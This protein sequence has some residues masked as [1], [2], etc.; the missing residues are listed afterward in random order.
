MERNGLWNRIF[1]RNYTDTLLW[2][3]ATEMYRQADLSSI[4]PLE[5]QLRTPS[6]RP[7]LLGE[8]RMATDRQELV[9]SV[10][11]RRSEL[12]RGQDYFVDGSEGKLL[13]YAPEENLA[14]GAAKHASNG[15]FDV[16]N[17]PPWDTWVV[18]SHGIL[19]SWVPPQ[20]IGL[21]QS[22]IEVNPECCVRWL[23]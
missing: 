4:A 5:A 7:T 10:V 13:L 22:G 12:V 11:V 17:V 21:A 16:D 23:D 6:L 14:D 9:R 2:R 3:K 8:A 1:R 19:L 15:F 18:F 20:L